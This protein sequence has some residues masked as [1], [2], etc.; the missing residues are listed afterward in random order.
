MRVR[1][2]EGPWL[3]SRNSDHRFLYYVL[4]SFLTEVI[5]RIEHGPFFVVKKKET[6]CFDGKCATKYER[7]IPCLL[8]IP[9]RFSASLVTA[10]GG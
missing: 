3:L 5:G 10:M 2:E 7:L 8:F 9:L 4:H 1:V 6:Q